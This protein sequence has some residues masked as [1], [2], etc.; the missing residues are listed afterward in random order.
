M[1]VLIFYLLF[2]ALIAWF[3]LVIRGF[4]LLSREINVYNR[5]FGIFGLAVVFILLLI[6]LM[7]IALDISLA[8]NGL[9]ISLLLNLPIVVV[10]LLIL[11][12]TGLARAF[13]KRFNSKV[14]YFEDLEKR[15]IRKIES[16]SKARVDTLRKINHVL[17]FVGLFAVWAVSLSVVVNFS[18]SWSGMIP[19]ENN[20]LLIYIQLL[21]NSKNVSDVLFSFGWFYY[22]LFFFFYAFCF[23][24]LANELTR[25]KP[26][27]TFPFNYMTRLLLSE[28]ERHGYGTYLYFAIG[29]MFAALFCPPMVFFAILGMS[30]IGD[31]MASQVGIRY[32]KT[33]ISWNQKK[34]WEGT[35]AATITCFIICFFFIGIIWGLIFSVIFMIFDVFSGKGFRNINL[36]DNLLIPIGCALVYLFIRFSLNLNYFTIILTW[37]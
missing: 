2:V 36:S 13:R 15:T 10:G 16:M 32:G 29:Q 26:R 34:T 12:S 27:Y 3:L 4:F 1:I 11:L 25:K 24:M 6:I 37:F 7:L 23:I 31:L 35:V 9:L 20:I 21:T 33:H 5:F 30:S 28:D 18:G 17:I 8:F 19:V 14:K 22:I